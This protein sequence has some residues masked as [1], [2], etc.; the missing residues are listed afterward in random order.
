[1][2]AFLAAP[3]EQRVHGFDIE[4]LTGLSNAAVQQSCD[5]QMCQLPRRS[6]NCP[7]ASS[8]RTQALLRAALRNLSFH[9]AIAHKMLLLRVPCGS[10]SAY[11]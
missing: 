8:Q 2:E 11:H 4:R 6:C 10:S 3:V 5:A 1:M 7:F 9:A